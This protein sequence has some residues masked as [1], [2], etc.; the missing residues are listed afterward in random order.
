MTPNPF[1]QRLQAGE[2]L[3]GLWSSLASP[4]V[5]EVLSYSDF[6]WLMID[7]EHTPADAALVQGILR[8]AG[9]RGPHVVVRP[10]WADPVTIKRMLDIGARTLLLPFIQTPDEAAAAVAATRYPP[11]GLRGVAG[12]TRAS[13]YGTQP[14]YLARAADGLCVLVQV[15]T[16]EAV[17]RAGEIASV[18]GVDGVFIGPSD[19]SASMGHLGN[20]GAEEV[21][22]TIA[23]ALVAVT[24]AGKPAGIL[25]PKRD[26]ARRYLDLG[27]TFLA[28]GID[29]SLLLSAAADLKT[30]IAA[31]VSRRNG[32]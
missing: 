32:D 18:P 8:A 10:P 12:L 27:V 29:I 7:T 24:T 4:T 11:Y 25:A 23:R 5:A 21:Q 22:L 16:L 26:D 6:D 13:A 17:E 15:E 20:P 1:K 9:E 30:D 31:H 19:L 28:A 2:T 14:G 3:L